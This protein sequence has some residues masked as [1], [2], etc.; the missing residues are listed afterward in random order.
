MVLSKNNSGSGITLV[1]WNVRGLGLA[2]KR[3]KILSHLK[4]LSADVAFLQ[5]TH[6]RPKECNLLRC[7]WADQ[8]YQSTFSSK[9]RG[10]AIIIKKNTSFNHISTVTDPNG[11]FLIVTGYLYSM[12]VTLVNIYGPNLD[13]PGFFRKIFNKLTDLSNTNLIVAGDY[14]LVMDVHLDRSSSRDCAPSNASTTLKCIMSSSNIVDIWR[15]QHPDEREYSF[16]SS[17]HRSYS[18]IDFFLVDAKLIPIVANSNYH[19]ILIS[20]HAPTLLFSI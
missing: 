19:N 5:E 17:V 3:A 14:N 9:A 10:V 15:I 18:R 4:S 8:I 20:D 12:H 6:I 11:H 13:D 2:T 16:F 7:R 1:S